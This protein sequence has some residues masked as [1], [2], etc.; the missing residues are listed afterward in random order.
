MAWKDIFFCN[1]CDKRSNEI[2]DRWI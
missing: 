1:W 2:W